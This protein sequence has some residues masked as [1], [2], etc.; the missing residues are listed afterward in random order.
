MSANNKLY[1]KVEIDESSQSLQSMTSKKNH[2]L[3]IKK[4]KNMLQTTENEVVFI[5][6]ALMDTIN[7]LIKEPV[8]FDCGIPSL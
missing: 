1:F 2:S 7:A 4:N 5:D 8:D 6:Y 3:V